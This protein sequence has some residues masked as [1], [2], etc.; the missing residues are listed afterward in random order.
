MNDQARVWAAAGQDG[1]RLKPGHNHGSVSLGQQRQPFRRFAQELVGSIDDLAASAS[2]ASA[3]QGDQHSA[4]RLQRTS[5]RST[6][7]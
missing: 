4:G 3:L 1:S 5:D 2:S 6:A 7:D